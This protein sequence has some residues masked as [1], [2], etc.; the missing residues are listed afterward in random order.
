MMM[1][2]FLA[3]SSLLSFNTGFAIWIL[4]SLIV[5]LG[6]MYKF[7]LPP[8]IKG[9]EEREQSIQSSLAERTAQSIRKEATK[10]VE[11]FRAERM[12]KAKEEAEKLIEDAKKSIDQ[13][14]QKALNELRK[15]VT[16]LTIEATTRLLQKNVDSETNRKL[17]DDTINDLSKN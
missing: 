8:I 14:K 2:L 7:A 4:I 17:I 9:I 13:E 11:E 6:I 12:D 15:E 1:S 16:D 10:E 5:F 3:G